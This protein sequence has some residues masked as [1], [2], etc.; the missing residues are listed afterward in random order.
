VSAEEV[1]CAWE[2]KRFPKDD[3]EPRAGYGLVHFKDIAPEEL[4]TVSGL[5]LEKMPPWRGPAYVDRVD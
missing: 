5:P 4:H 1:Y 3:F 2:E